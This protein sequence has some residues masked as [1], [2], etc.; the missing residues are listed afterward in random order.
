MSHT[1]A[2]TPFTS[3]P[4]KPRG[5]WCLWSLSVSVNSDQVSNGP[6]HT[7]L[8]PFC[9]CMVTQVNGHE[10]LWGKDRGNHSWGIYLP[11]CCR[12]F[13]P[14]LPVPYSS[15]DSGLKIGSGLETE[16]GSMT[17]WGWPPLASCS[18]ILVGFFWLWSLK[19]TL[20]NWVY[21]APRDAIFY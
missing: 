20:L 10:S 21:F 7:W 19:I 3:E 14:R 6:Q 11:W 5:W 15:M 13:V 9:Q 12:G 16:H 17:Y 2:R 1:L 18:S 8:F 4:Q